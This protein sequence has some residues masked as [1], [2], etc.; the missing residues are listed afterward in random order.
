MRNNLILG[1]HS[2][3][4]PLPTAKHFVTDIQRNP[5]TL[6][7]FLKY[8]RDPFMGKDQHRQKYPCERIQNRIHVMLLYNATWDLQ[9]VSKFSPRYLYITVIIFLFKIIKIYNI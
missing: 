6:F 3:E 5:P 2:K 9:I 4:I 8:L 7:V 1:W